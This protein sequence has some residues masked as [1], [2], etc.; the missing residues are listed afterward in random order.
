L[1]SSVIPASADEKM[2]TQ[3]SGE[4]IQVEYGYS[5]LT[6]TCNISISSKGKWYLDSGCSRNMTGDPSFFKETTPLSHPVTIKFGDGKM[7]NSL[8]S[9]PVSTPIG[10]VEALFV[11][12]LCANLLSVHELT[13]WVQVFVSFQT[14]PRFYINPKDF[15]CL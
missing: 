5:A 2:S 13:L 6:E 8:C 10:I 3:V 11:P 4:G 12:Q 14:V 15:Q 1:T 9:G 7:L